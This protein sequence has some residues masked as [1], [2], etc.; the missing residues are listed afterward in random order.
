MNISRHLTILCLLNTCLQPVI[1]SN[2]EFSDDERFDD[3]SHISTTRDID[4]DS[5]FEDIPEDLGTKSTSTPCDILKTL[6][7]FDVHK[8]LA[9]DLYTVTYPLASRNILKNALLQQPIPQHSACNLSFFY[10]QSTNLFPWCNGIDGYINL[11]KTEQLR[12]LENEIIKEMSIDIPKTL[13]LFKGSWAEERRIGIYAGFWKT[14][15]RSFIGGLEIPLYVVERNYNLLPEDQQAIKENFAE[16][17]TGL[18][19]GPNTGTQKEVEQAAIKYLAESRLGIGDTRLTLAWHALNTDRIKLALGLQAIIPTAS[20]F[21]TSIIGSDFKAVLRRRT[22]DIEKFASSL[23]APPEEGEKTS[24]QD[25]IFS[26]AQDLL[27]QSANQAGALILATDL[28]EEQRFQLGFLV[29]P[30]IRIDQNVALIASCTINWQLPKHTSRFILEQQN[31]N[32]FDD[33][34]FDPDGKSEEECRRAVDFLSARAT[35][36]VFPQKYCVHLNDLIEAHIMA[37]ALFTFTDTWSVTLGYDYWTKDRESLTSIRQTCVNVDLHTIK[38]SLALK[39]T[40]SQHTVF[41]K[42]HYTKFKEL[43]DISVNF[44]ANFFVV[45]KNTSDTYTGFINVEWNF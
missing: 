9:D 10:E 41:T 3:I 7:E 30:S 32:D 37:G 40:A 23:T 1:L 42:I 6:Y 33:S 22:I 24:N 36:W 15:W 35:N 11:L 31:P 12:K 34:N 20:T 2:I 38:S 4:L 43:Y 44:G 28:G 17:A 16:I 18:G 27:L 5:L 21:T 13:S 39:P 29:Q 19:Y 14:L 26:E 45:S 8:I 25:D